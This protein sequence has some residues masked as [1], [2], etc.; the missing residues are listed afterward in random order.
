MDVY[1]V[2]HY[3][4]AEGFLVCL[5]ISLLVTQL[6]PGSLLQ[7]RHLKFLTADQGVAYSPKGCNL[8]MLT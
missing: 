1:K 7:E 5:E 8:F 6:P 3:Y 2:V 4:S